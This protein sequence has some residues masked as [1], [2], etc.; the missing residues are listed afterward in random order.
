MIL[1]ENPDYD[2]FFNPLCCKNKKIYYECILQLIEKSKQVTL[3]Y[4]DVYEIIE[5]D[6]RC[7]IDWF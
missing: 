3:L 4:E 5:P 2:K 1:F 7:Q 6:W